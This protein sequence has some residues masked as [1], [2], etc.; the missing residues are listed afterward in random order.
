MNKKIILSLLLTIFLVFT[1]NVPSFAE[2]IQSA[3]IG[4]W[5][6]IVNFTNDYYDNSTVYSISIEWDNDDSIIVTSEHRIDTTYFNN[7][8]EDQNSII[9]TITPGY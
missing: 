5:A 7:V 2:M 4:V 9:I 6:K 1:F 3:E 8:N